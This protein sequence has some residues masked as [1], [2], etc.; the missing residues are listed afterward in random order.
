VQDLTQPYH[1]STLPG[2]HPA[3]MI[4]VGVAAMAGW[5][6]PKLD[7]IT[8]A[9]NRHV[10]LENY[11]HKRMAQAYEQRRLDDPLLTALRDVSQD[12]EHW[13]FRLGNVRE[14]IAR[15]AFDAA[16][17]LDAQLEKSFPPRYA[18]DPA[19]NLGTEMDA[20]DMYGIA[21]QHSAP[22]HERLERHV[23]ALL[24]RLG[25]HTRALM[26]E[27]LAAKAPPPVRP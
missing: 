17:A 24:K 7:A 1:A 11:Q 21:R 16:P 20:L 23:A 25:L 12:P 8:L 3:R 18:A 13:Q 19:V 9:S 6:G 4:G 14:L 10:V 15:E 27:L 26:R 5:E 2:V 22:E